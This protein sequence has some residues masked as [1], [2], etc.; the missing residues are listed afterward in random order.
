MGAGAAHYPGLAPRGYYRS[1]LEGLNKLSW[2]LGG[3]DDDHGLANNTS[4][5]GAAAYAL[6]HGRAMGGHKEHHG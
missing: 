6:S 4:R 5:G 1:P 2:A 3:H